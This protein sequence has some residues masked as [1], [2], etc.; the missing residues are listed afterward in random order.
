ML[1]GLG[2]V[3]R[4]VVTHYR[5]GGQVFTGARLAEV[6]HRWVEAMLAADQARCP[7][8]WPRPRAAASGGVLS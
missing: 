5:G 7:G 4:G 6:D 8:P 1:A 2:R 3:L